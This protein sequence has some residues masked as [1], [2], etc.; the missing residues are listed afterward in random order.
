MMSVVYEEHTP[1]GWNYNPSGWD[2]RIP[3][4]GLAFLGFGIASYLAL[5]QLNFFSNVWEPFF[6]EGSRNVLHSSISRILPIPDG[7]IGAIAYAVDFI[8]GVIGGKRR[9]RNMPWIVILFGIAVGPLGLVSI[10]LVIIQPVLFH[11]WC[12]LCL[13]SAA[14][15]VL[16][17]GPAMDE[18]LASLQYLKRVKNS[19]NSVWKAFWGE[20]KIINKIN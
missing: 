1:P 4:L 19:G 3:L 18:M 6:G 20:K 14:I 5:Y 13:S 2:D 9:W 11:S 15:S 16:M 12:T 8:T 7:A 10:L 17:I